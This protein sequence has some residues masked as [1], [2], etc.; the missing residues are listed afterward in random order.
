[1]GNKT[2][3]CVSGSPNG[4]TSGIGGNSKKYQQR[5]NNHFHHDYENP[6]AWIREETS[7]NLQHISEREPDGKKKLY[8]P[9]NI[10]SFL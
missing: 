7:G 5:N 9:S 2:S 10:H 6:S 8:H 3:C 4:S 1:M